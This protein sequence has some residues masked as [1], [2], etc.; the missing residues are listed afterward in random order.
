MKTDSPAVM[1]YDPTLPRAEAAERVLT[2]VSAGPLQGSPAVFSPMTAKLAYLL[3]VARGR[4]AFTILSGRPQ[5][6]GDE[7]FRHRVTAAMRSSGSLAEFGDVLFRRLS[8]SLADLATADALWWRTFAADYAAQWRY[9]ATE[10]VLTEAVTGA[11]LLRSWA[12][13]RDG[14]VEG[15]AHGPGATPELDSDPIFP[16]TTVEVL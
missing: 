4:A 14:S 1:A 10:T 3:W 6:E 13:K 7:T 8:L 9:L 12:G 5:Y 11:Q 2:G 16:T 15:W